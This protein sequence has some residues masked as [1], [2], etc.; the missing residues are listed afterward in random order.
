V[1]V[2]VVAAHPDDEVLGCGGAILRHRS[3]G[4]DVRVVVAYACR[5]SEPDATWL[6]GKQGKPADKAAIERIV[7]E[8]QPEMVYTHFAGDINADHR[9]VHDAVMVACRPYAAPSVDT[10][11]A[12]Y[13][14]S[15][16][17]WGEAFKPTLY[18][19][20]T[21]FIED[22]V[23]WFARDY[24]DELR[25]WPHPRSPRA[26]GETAAYWGSHVG[27]GASEPFIVEREIR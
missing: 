25:P 3:Q 11:R 8:F 15:S 7:A 4:H 6:R 19:D 13:T 5:G 12:F 10:I 17:E 16:V 18:L 1:R 9:S 22:K 24:P 21:D 23:A 2:L 27:Q 20:I 14:P 26:I